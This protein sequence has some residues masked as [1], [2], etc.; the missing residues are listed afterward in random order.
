MLW[1]KLMFEHIMEILEN[2]DYYGYNIY[3]ENDPWYQQFWQSIRHTVGDLA[4]ISISSAQHAL[5]TGGTMAKDV[6]LCHPRLRSG[7]GLRREERHLEPHCVPLWRA[8][9]AGITP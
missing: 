5:D 1:S 7:A 3:D 6:P 4:P 8:R 2:R 9:R